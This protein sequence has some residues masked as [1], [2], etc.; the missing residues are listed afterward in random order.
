MSKPNLEDF[1]PICPFPVTVRVLDDRGLGA[2][3][4]EGF[5]LQHLRL[6]RRDSKGRLHIIQTVRHISNTQLG[7]IILARRW[8]NHEPEAGA[9]VALKTIDKRCFTKLELPGRAPLFLTFRN[10][11][12]KYGPENPEIEL[13]VLGHLGGQHHL[14]GLLDYLEGEEKNYMVIDYAKGS[15]RYAKLQLVG[16]IKVDALCTH[17]SDG[18]LLDH[19]Q[20][21]LLSEQQ[22][23]EIIC[24]MLE[25]KSK[26]KKLGPLLLLTNFRIS[27]PRR[28]SSFTLPRRVPQRYIA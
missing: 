21:T 28:V 11:T 12:L 9:P 10:G 18:D 22:A 24:Q 13:K 17:V 7:E 1:D 4:N 16:L 27:Y 15:S 26:R 14:V 2:V 6:E 25:G 5:P 3:D 23:K 20:H 8:V 19:V